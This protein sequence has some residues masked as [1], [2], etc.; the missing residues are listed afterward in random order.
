MMTSK[1]VVRFGFLD[2]TT[3]K[4]GVPFRHSLDMSRRYLSGI[5]L[6]AYLST[7]SRRSKPGW[8]LPRSRAIAADRLVT[9]SLR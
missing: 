1:G 4:C 3:P 8:S 6:Q 5:S 2:G 7:R 9:P